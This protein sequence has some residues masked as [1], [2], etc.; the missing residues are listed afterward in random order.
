MYWLQAN[1]HAGEAYRPTSPTPQ[2]LCGCPPSLSINGEGRGREIAEATAKDTRMACSAVAE[3]FQ[4]A[5]VAQIG[6]TFCGILV[7][8]FVFD[9]VDD[10][11]DFVDGSVDRMLIITI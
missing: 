4:V 7:E 5:F 10:G 2:Q 6:T 11:R 3:M 9:F 8:F 1:S